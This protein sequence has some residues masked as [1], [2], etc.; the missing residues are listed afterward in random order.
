MRNMNEI[1]TAKHIC[2][3]S[4][5]HYTVFIFFNN[6]MNKPPKTLPVASGENLSLVK[7][8]TFKLYLSSHEHSAW[9]SAYIRQNTPIECFAKC[10]LFPWSGTGKSIFGLAA[11]CVNI[12]GLF[13][14]GINA[15]IRY[16]SQV[17]KSRQRNDIG[18]NRNWAWPVVTC[19]VNPALDSQCL[20]VSSAWSW[21]WHTR[22]DQVSKSRFI[23]KK[24]NPADKITRKIVKEKRVW[25]RWI[26]YMLAMS[27]H[28]IS[29]LH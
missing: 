16:E 8:Q 1:V 28:G 4:T 11:K 23:M 22:W 24:E 20:K 25:I 17:E 26:F 5:V 12:C 18:I 27:L 13:Q 10:C 19:R 29:H 6:W 15:D 9:P 2:R 21:T 14:A 7:A 3:V